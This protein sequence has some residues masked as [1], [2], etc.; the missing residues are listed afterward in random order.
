MKRTIILFVII[1]W[2]SLLA[3]QCPY[4]NTLNIIQSAP[5]ETGVTITDDCIRPGQFD[6]LT[7]MQSGYIY[8]ISTCPNWDYDTKITVYPENGGEVLG[9]DDDYCGTASQV[10]FTAP[11]TGSFDIVVDEYPCVSGD[12]CLIL[13]VELIYAANFDCP[14]G[15]F[16]E[17][18]NCGEST[19]DG[20]VINVPY[21]EAI[22]V[23]TSICGS[24][25]MN[26]GGGN[27]TADKDYYTFTMTEPGNVTIHFGSEFPG[28]VSLN[29]QPNCYPHTL[30][31]DSLVPG[32]DDSIVFA[33]L[34]NQYSI[35]VV[36]DVTNIVCGTNN[37]YFISLDEGG[38]PAYCT[39]NLYS[40]P[41]AGP[42]INYFSLNTINNNG[43]GL[44]PNSYGD[45]TSMS[46]ELNAGNTFMV[47]LQ[48]LT[49]QQ[50][51]VSIWIDYNDNTSFELNEAV[52]FNYTLWSDGINQ[53]AITIPADANQGTHRLRVR[54]AYWESSCACCTYLGGEVEDYTVV[55]SGP[56][57]QSSIIN[58]VL[59]Y[60][61]DVNTPLDSVKIYLMNQGNI[62]DSTLTD[63]GGNYE[64]TGIPDGTYALIVNCD[65]PFGGINATDA[66]IVLKYY[67]GAENL[68]GLPLAAANV[69]ENPVINSADALIV[70]KRF[71]HMIGSFIVGDWIFEQPE[72]QINAQGIYNADIHGLCH[73]DVDASFTP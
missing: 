18:E 57:A 59:T 49:Y 17:A 1:C 7:D 56:G 25:W 5:A 30:I 39:E 70:F 63:E 23:G 58:G 8:R 3:G 62:M 12:Y 45:F 14:A 22:T 19:N 38:V 53:T 44:S 36:P 33:L 55:I 68:W 21:F 65:K 37:R 51:T 50:I 31:Q 71:V 24:V 40:N 64:F 29:H 54:A 66:L 67:T 69:N 2:V 72:I 42:A 52:L 10:M 26:P 27:T 73:G 43:S 11:Y 4:D 47:Q 16:N 28:F 32:S 46:T 15:A 60:A 34:P 35:K 48:T 9:Y 20:C 6:R 61:N 41:T 13:E